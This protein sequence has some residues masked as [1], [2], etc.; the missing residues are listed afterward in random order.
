MSGLV[1]INRKQ[2]DT[3]HNSDYCF[4]KEEIAE[5]VV[6]ILNWDSKNILDDDYTFS[7]SEDN[8]V[9]QPVVMYW[10]WNEK[11]VTMARNQTPEI[12]E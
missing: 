3:T 2:N 1:L 8:A 7:I 12:W 4:C 5:D 10:H 6:K 11:M 9:G